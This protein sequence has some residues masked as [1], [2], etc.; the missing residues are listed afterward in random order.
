MRT[1]GEIY[2]R[3]MGMDID[4]FFFHLG[5]NANLAFYA[6]GIDEALEF[7]RECDWLK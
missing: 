4:L 2:R 7:R 1:A 3:D 6:G 5:A